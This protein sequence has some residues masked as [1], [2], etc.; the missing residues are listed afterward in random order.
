MRRS[1]GFAIVVIL[2]LAV[3]IGANTAIFSLLD[4]MLLRP[5]PVPHPEQLVQVTSGDGPFASR[6]AVWEQIRD[7]H[8]FAGAFAWSFNRFNTSTSGEA[9]YIDG[10][11]ASGRIFD[12]LGIHAILGRTLRATD[13]RRGGGLD[14]PV[15]NI[16]YE[17]W[18]RRFAGAHDVIGQSLTIERVPFTIVGVLPRSFHGLDIG[19]PFDVALPIGASTLTTSTTAPLAEGGYYVNIMARLRPGETVAAAGARLGAAQTAIREATLPDLTYQSDRDTYLREALSVHA[20]PDGRSFLRPFYEKALQILWALAA[21]VLLMTCASVANL[22]LTR[23]MARRRELN[24]RAA[25]GAS[26]LL[27]LR[28]ILAESVWLAATGVAVAILIG[29]ASSRLLASRLSTDR[30]LVSLNLGLDWR[31]LA[32]AAACGLGTVIIFGSVPALYAARAT[33]LDALKHGSAQA[34]ARRPAWNAALIVL[35]VALSLALVAASG[36]LIRSWRALDAIDPGFDAD[37]VLVVNVEELHPPATPVARLALYQSV[38]RAVAAVPGVAEAAVSKTLP[39]GNVRMRP[40]VAIPGGIVMSA[41]DRFLAG[42][43]VAPGWFRTVGTPLQAGRDFTDGDRP[44]SP[45]VGIVNHAF[46]ERLLDGG[47]AVGRTIDLFDGT[48]RRPL[49]I[50]GVVGDTVQDSLRGGLPPA[51]YLP[52]AQDPLSDIP[53]FTLSVRAAGGS[54]ARLGPAVAAAIARVDPDLVLNLRTL[55]DQLDESFKQ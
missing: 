34:G 26:R 6:F 42:N 47:H 20:A 19:L 35:Q 2:T 13:D 25:L 5:L 39:A 15:A 10:I 22:L 51:L 9:R 54:P 27:L 21:L 28:G 43:S 3:G 37:R 7:R 49:T 46:I 23:T 31:V 33:P 48:T 1:P 16:S 52:M 4:A 8:L 18:Q 24:V 32:F 50:V 30:Y 11:W 17:F 45:L 29:E 41:S 55:T 44:N 40:L 38:T 36:L 12:V 53:M 14:G